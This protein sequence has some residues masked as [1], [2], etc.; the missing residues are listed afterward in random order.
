MGIGN[1]GQAMFPLY[2]N[3]TAS[4]NRHESYTCKYTMDVQQIPDYIE[5][6]NTTIPNSI[7]QYPPV[8]FLNRNVRHIL[9]E[10]R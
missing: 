3:K 7:P 4:N 9:K 6:L 8:H 10:F 1:P 2:V 5:S